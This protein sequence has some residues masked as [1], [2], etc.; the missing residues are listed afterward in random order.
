MHEKLTVERRQAKVGLGIGYG[1][2]RMDLNT[3]DV[4]NQIHKIWMH[5]GTKKA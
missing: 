4:T 5:E 1:V 2:S 3:E